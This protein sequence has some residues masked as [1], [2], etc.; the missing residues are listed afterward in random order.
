M[1]MLY[2]TKNNELKSGIMNSF[3]KEIDVLIDGYEEQLHTL[4]EERATKEKQV[5]NLSEELRS[6]QESIAN[7]EEDS[8]QLN[9]K[10]ELMEDFLYESSDNKLVEKYLNSYREYFYQDGINNMIEVIEGFME[11]KYYF[12][13]AYFIDYLGEKSFI[14]Y[15]S[16]LNNPKF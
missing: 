8:L 12:Q 1:N 3:E 10:L 7:L 11:R 2:Q 5:H 6:K 9:K 14:T 4:E 15:N 13:S 16:L